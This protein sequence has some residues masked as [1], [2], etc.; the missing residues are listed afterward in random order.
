[1]FKWNFYLFFSVESTPK[2]KLNYFLKVSVHDRYLND[3][4]CTLEVGDKA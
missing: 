2:K 1:M 3:R 4:D